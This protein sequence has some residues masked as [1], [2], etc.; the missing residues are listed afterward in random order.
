MAKRRSGGRDHHRDTTAAEGHGSPAQT[1]TTGPGPVA[2][3]G[4][5]ITDHNGPGRLGKRI[6]G[7]SPDM[8]NSRKTPGAQKNVPNK[9]RGREEDQ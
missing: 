9:T 4:E 8:T 5:L 1:H 3:A 2:G 6:A 7:M